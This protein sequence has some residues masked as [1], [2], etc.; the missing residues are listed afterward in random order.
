[1]RL[2]LLNEMKSV[3]WTPTFMLHLGKAE[4]KKMINVVALKQRFIFVECVF[5][6]TAQLAIVVRY[7]FIACTDFCKRTYGIYKDTVEII[8]S[9][10]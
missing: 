6:L 4:G 3:S 5:L 2:L 1:M 10:M 7:N 9:T 8:E